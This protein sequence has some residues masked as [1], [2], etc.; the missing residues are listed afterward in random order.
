[1]GNEN[2]ENLLQASIEC[3]AAELK[4]RIDERKDQPRQVIV[5]GVPPRHGVADVLAELGIESPIT[6]I[7]TGVPR[8]GRDDDDEYVAELQTREPVAPADDR[9]AYAERQPVET[10]SVPPL[11]KPSPPVARSESVS[12]WRCVR[13]QV[14]SPDPDR[15]DP[16]EIKEGQYR[17]EGDL[18]RVQ[19]LEGRSLGTA[20]LQ[21]GDDADAAARKTLRESH[22]R[23]GS[24]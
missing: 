8:A 4:K 10:V 5:T 11:P 21:P 20:M 9:Y 22:G 18:L 12:E 13:A 1:M 15:N 7:I 24:F 19:D 16:G 3:L 14:R 6:H 23:H 17:V 2:D